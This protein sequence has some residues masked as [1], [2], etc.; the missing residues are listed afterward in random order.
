MMVIFW[1]IYEAE[2]SV[3]LKKSFEII[4]PK[5]SFWTKMTQICSIYNANIQYSNHMHN[6]SM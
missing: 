6:T 1:N 4:Y 2:E 3:S 5:M